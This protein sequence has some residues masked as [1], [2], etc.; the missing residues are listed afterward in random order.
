[1]TARN[2]K[3]THIILD[4]GGNEFQAQL[5]TWQLNDNTNNPTTQFVFEP[6]EEFVEQPDPDYTLD[7]TFFADWATTGVSKWLWQ[8][9]G[10]QVPFTLTHHPDIPAE[11]TTFSGQLLVKAPS[12][13]GDIRTTEQSTVTF[14]VVGDVV[15]ADA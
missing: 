12:V 15:M 1:M 3:L 7:C 9:R 5:S 13:G 14:P 4:I 10:E 11:A 8:H 6:G 2:R